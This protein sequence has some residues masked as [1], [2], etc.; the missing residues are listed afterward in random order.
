LIERE[1][2]TDLGPAVVIL[3]GAHNIFRRD[4]LAIRI[5][6]DGFISL[7]LVS[8]QVITIVNIIVNDVIVVLI[9]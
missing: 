7:T 8:D 6:S 9:T 2:V 4:P 1:G 3:S 5:S